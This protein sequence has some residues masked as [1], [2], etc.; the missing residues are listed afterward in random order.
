M[1]NIRPGE[2]AH[3]AGNGK[4]NDS[5]FVG[6]IQLLTPSDDNQSVLKAT[7]QFTVKCTEEA[8]SI[9]QHDLAISAGLSRTKACFIAIKTFN[10]KLSRC[11]GL[12]T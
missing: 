12:Q 7:C 9:V 10:C 2:L 5:M 6:E 1:E 8:L 3:D 4:H 11:A